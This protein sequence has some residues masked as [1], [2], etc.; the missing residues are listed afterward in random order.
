MF[1]SEILTYKNI[2]IIFSLFFAFLII[3]G[4]TYFILTLR[5]SFF[6]TT[7]NGKQLSCQ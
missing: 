5:R 3:V 7:S 2:P 1:N 4:V 6:G